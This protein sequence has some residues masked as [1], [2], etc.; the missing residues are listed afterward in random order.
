MYADVRSIHRCFLDALGRTVY[1]FIRH[2]KASVQPTIIFFAFAAASA[3]E[4]YGCRLAAMLAA[5]I[6][7]AGVAAAGLSRSYH[8]DGVLR[9]VIALRFS[10]FGPGNMST[11]PLSPRSE[12]KCV[13]STAEFTAWS[14]PAL[15]STY[16]S[17]AIPETIPEMLVIAT[18]AV[19]E[20]GA[21]G[22]LLGGARATARERSTNH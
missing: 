20:V 16:H 11:C 21:C 6:S 1:R 12:K 18:M 7:E 19:L 14:T 10:S 4:Y 5:T 22:I 15:L 8:G 2:K 3:D 9:L 13:E 17:W